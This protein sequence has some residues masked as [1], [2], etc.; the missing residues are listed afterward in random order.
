MLKIAGIDRVGALTGVLLDLVQSAVDPI[1]V[2]A[3]PAGHPVDA[4]PADQHVVAAAADQR[5]A[6]AATVECVGR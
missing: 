4:A 6:A 2:V 5:V 3:E 1:D